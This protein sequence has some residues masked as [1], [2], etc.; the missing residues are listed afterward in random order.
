[1]ETLATFVVYGQARPK[2]SKTTFITDAAWAKAKREG[3]K[4]FAVSKE[5]DST[6]Q[7]VRLVSQVMAQ[8]LQRPYTKE[9]GPLAVSV[10]F[11]FPRPKSRPTDVWYANTPDA[12]K[13]IRAIGDAGNG[14]A[15]ADD[16]MIAY[17]IVRK[18]YTDG[19]ARVVI[20]IGRPTTED[21]IVDP[22]E[23]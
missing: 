5:P 15:W 11:Y 21:L 22:S 9:E 4:P 17:W 3:R 18:F 14:V 7:W 2:G 16:K 12:D 6:T 1:M 13:L 20:R 10:I 8:E 23:P 19:A